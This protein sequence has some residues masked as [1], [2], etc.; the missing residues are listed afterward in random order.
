[1]C[2]A[3]ITDFLR[4]KQT[5]SDTT[6]TQRPDFTALY[7][8]VPVFIDEEKEGDNIA[9]A[10]DDVI[11]KF[12]WI[13]NLRRLPFFIGFAF[14]FNHVRI[15][16]LARNEPLQTL[17]SHALSSFEDRLAVLQPAV[18]IA[19]ALKHF[20]D[21]DMI[22]PAG[23]SMGKWHKRR[24]GKQIKLSLQGVEVKCTNQTKFQF[25]KKFYDQCRNVQY[26]ERLTDSNSKNLK[27]NLGPL[28]LSVLPATVQQFYRAVKCIATA[29]Y[30]MHDQGY[31]HTDIRWPNIVLMDDGNWMLVDCYEACKLNDSKGLL[32]IAV[33]RRLPN[34][35][36]RK[37]E[38]MVQLA[39]LVGALPF[40]QNV[41]SI[42]AVTLYNII[43]HCDVTLDNII[44][45]CDKYM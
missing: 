20:I 13:P 29:L 22:T 12:N 28:G 37:H 21:S 33:D 1:M 36:W 15:L 40:V 11:N 7:G 42:S 32:K 39:G 44:T 19:R 43:T 24:D 3:G 18:N 34:C 25:L 31:V 8:G 26:L 45:H 41:N 5:D 2:I 6:A 30:G 38:D 27:L 10:V 23:L 16:R 35:S 4:N 9:A 17:F 14:S